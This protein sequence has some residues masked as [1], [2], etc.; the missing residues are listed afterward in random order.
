MLTL[1]LPHALEQR[2]R[3][4][5]KSAGAC[6]IGGIVVAEHTGHSE[7]LV[8][9]MTFH[10]AGTFARFIRRIEDALGSLKAFFQRTKHEYTRFNYI[11]EWHSHPSFAPEPSARDDETMVEIATDRNVG[12]NF[13]V[14][15]IVKLNDAGSLLQSLHTYLPDGSKHRSRVVIQSPSI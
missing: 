15:L 9:D 10:K 4:E 6:E 7:F 2:L 14:L 3:R 11:G 13:V 8:H 5:L 1:I 12:A